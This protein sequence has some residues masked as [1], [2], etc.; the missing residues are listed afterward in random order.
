MA[1]VVTSSNDLPVWQRLANY[2]QKGDTIGAE[3]SVFYTDGDGEIISRYMLS[4]FY[5]RDRPNK[6]RLVFMQS[7]AFSSRL[8]TTRFDR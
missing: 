4:T 1:A 6:Y 7:P 2:M 8:P 5:G 3:V